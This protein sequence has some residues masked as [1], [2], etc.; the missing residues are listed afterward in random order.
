MR[1]FSVSW[2]LHIRLLVLLEESGGGGKGVS[3]WA[4]IA[5]VSRAQKAGGQGSRPQAAGTYS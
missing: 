1:P 2:C 4:L 3:F 5:A